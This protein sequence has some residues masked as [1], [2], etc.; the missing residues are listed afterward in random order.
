MGN[1]YYLVVFISIILLAIGI[2][3]RLRFGGENK[4]LAGTGAPKPI[5]GRLP[6]TNRTL[7]SDAEQSFYRALH[8]ALDPDLVIFS[9]VRLANLVSVER[10]TPDAIA[11]R[12]STSG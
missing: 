11:T 6:Y 7:L 9:K 1:Q 10:G 8:L 12:C 4:R 2:G 3:V 5:N